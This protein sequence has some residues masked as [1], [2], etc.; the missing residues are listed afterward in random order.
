MTA[1]VTTAIGMPRNG[2]LVKNGNYQPFSD[3]D[4]ACCYTL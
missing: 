2:A 4:Y 1:H 3:D